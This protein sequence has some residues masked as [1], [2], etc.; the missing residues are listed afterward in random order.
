MEARVKSGDEG[1]P[2]RYLGDQ[3]KMAEGLGERS[4]RNESLEFRPCLG[5]RRQ[6]EGA[7]AVGDGTKVGTNAPQFS[8]IEKR[9]EHSTVQT[10]ER[11]GGAEGMDLDFRFVALPH[12]WLPERP[13]VTHRRTTSNPRFSLVQRYRTCLRPM[14]FAS[15]ICLNVLIRLEAK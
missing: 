4:R 9:P 3:L 8:R 15:L 10:L 5:R 6:E 2:N 13:F 12:T 1:S 11:D 14:A 7:L